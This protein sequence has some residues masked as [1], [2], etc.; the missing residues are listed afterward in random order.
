MKPAATLVF[1]IIATLALGA[2]QA[3]I[4]Q[5]KDSS[6]QTV[7]SDTPPPGS[8]ESKETRV[9]GGQPPV[10]RGESAAAKAPE[11]SEAPKTLAEKDL[12][13]KKRQQEARE[14]ADKEAKEQKA[15]ADRKDNCER[16]QRNL[17]ALESKRPMTKLDEKGNPNLI[18]DNQRQQEMERA[19]QIVAESC[20]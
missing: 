19:R 2:A 10:A 17:A 5:W 7:I 11:A 16:A 20:K 3:E 13:F 18:D 1:G 6:G 15:E 9:I 8:A 12:E 4:Y 14:K